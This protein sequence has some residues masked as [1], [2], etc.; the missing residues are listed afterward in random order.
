MALQPVLIDGNW[1]PAAAAGSFQAENPATGSRCRTSTRSAAGPIAMPRWPRRAAAAAVAAFHAGRANRRV[2]RRDSPQ[3]IEARSAELVEAAHA[4]TGLPKTPRLADVELPRTTG[5]LRQAAAAAR[6]GSWRCR[7]S[8]RREHSLVLGAARAGVRVWAEQFSVRVQ[9]RRGRRFRRRDRRRQSG[10]RQG[11]HVAS[12]HDAAAGRGGARSGSAKRDCRRARCSCIY[13]TEPRRRRAAGGRSAHRRHGLHRQPRGR[14]GAQ[15]GGRRGRQ[16]DLSGTVERQSGRRSCPA[17]WP[18]GASRSPGEFATSCL[19]GS[20]PVLHES[21]AGDS[22][23]RRRDRSVHRQR[24]PRNFAAA[25]VG[26]LLS[27]GVAESLAE[28]ASQR[29]SQAGAEVLA[30]GERRR[31]HRL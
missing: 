26:T 16:A 5:Q 12:R 4:E 10:H 21:R 17:R 31:R 22:A 7:R 2:S 27:R 20:G 1:R 28:A 15:G 14:A 19:M 8:T 11:Q 29:S 30:G 3:R 24:S 13:R 6:E 23:G 9:Q 18:S 25:P